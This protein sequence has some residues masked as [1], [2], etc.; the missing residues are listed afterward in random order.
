[1]CSCLGQ[2]GR[3]CAT[4]TDGDDGADADDCGARDVSMVVQLVSL[5]RSTLLGT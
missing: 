3:S 2:G 4:G 5:S 1:M